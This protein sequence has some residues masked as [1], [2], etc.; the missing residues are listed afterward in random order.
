MIH[1]QLPAPKKLFLIRI[2]SE[3]VYIFLLVLISSKAAYDFP[4]CD[5]RGGLYLGL[6]ATRGSHILPGMM[7]GDFLTSHSLMLPLSGW[8]A[9]Q[10]LFRIIGTGFQLRG[11]YISIEL[12]LFT[13]IMAA[14]LNLSVDIL[15]VIN[16]CLFN[17]VI[18][19]A[20][21]LMDIWSPSNTENTLVIFSIIIVES[22]ALLNA[23]LGGSIYAAAAAFVGIVLQHVL[24]TRLLLLKNEPS[25]AVKD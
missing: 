4:V 16:F 23:L 1:L 22:V 24:T 25:A 15:I 8:V 11:K 20:Y 13:F 18:Y 10:L 12:I 21:L 9:F 17:Y 7:L 5:F 6:I 14:G 19:R 3:Q 2:L